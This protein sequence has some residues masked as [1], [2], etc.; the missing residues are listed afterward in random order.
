MLRMTPIESKKVVISGGPGSGKTTLINLL[1]EKG[2]DCAD[3][4]SRS[5]IK[6]VEKVGEES[7][8]KSQPIPFSKKIWQ[9]RKQQYQ[10]PK[11]LSNSGPKPYVFF[12]RGLHDVVA[13]LDYIVAPYDSQ[14][15]DL[16]D[17]SYDLAILLPPWKKIYKNDSERYENF[18]EAEK[19]YFYIKNTYL[20]N[21]IPLVEIPFQS[22][23][24]RVSTILK[25][26]DDGKHS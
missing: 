5:I 19:L 1:R 20:K 24:R 6:E 7:P 14:K 16:S 15:F 18:E 11:F 21:Y 13:Y 9:G 26:L 23:E 12:D 8:F 2:Y 10:N 22:P 17:F 25:Y 4:F 3:E